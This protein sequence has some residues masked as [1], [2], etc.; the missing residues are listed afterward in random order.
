LQIT[1]SKQEAEQRAQNA[2]AERIASEQAAAERAAAEVHAERELEQAARQKADAEKQME[3]A[4]HQRAAAELELSTAAQQR[5]AAENEAWKAAQARLHAEQTARAA[6]LTRAGAEEQASLQAAVRTRTE[7]ELE[8]VRQNTRRRARALPFAR[9]SDSG[10]DAL[11]HG[12]R[13]N[14]RRWFATAA[15]LAL[16]IVIGAQLHDESSQSIA[17]IAADAP[18]RTPVGEARLLMDQSFEAFGARLDTRQR[19]NDNPSLSRP[20][21]A[22]QAPAIRETSASER[23]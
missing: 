8:H 1:R 17:P 13:S 12:A 20:P 16:G 14:V 10:G 21:A 19:S 7:Q 5:A 23:S 4:A 9:R 6:A 11:A 18:A 3:A 15:A 22:T 2:A